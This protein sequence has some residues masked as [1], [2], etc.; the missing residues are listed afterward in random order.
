MFFDEFAVSERPR[1]F[2]GWAERNTR[3]QVKSNERA[4]N[5]LNGLLCVD[6]HSGEEYFALSPQ[7]KTE[8]IAVAILFRTLDVEHVPL[9]L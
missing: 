5:K 6:A 3:P 4:R 2:Y 9:L 7:A 1:L 8:D